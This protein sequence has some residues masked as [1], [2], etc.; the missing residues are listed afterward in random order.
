MAEEEKDGQEHGGGR[1]EDR[2]TAV[3]YFWS[4]YAAPTGRC[5]DGHAVLPKHV[6]FVC[7]LVR[8][9]KAS[10]GLGCVSKRVLMGVDGH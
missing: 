10:M 5:C 6:F 3:D 9:S 1:Q 7:F 8:D 2:K 4:A